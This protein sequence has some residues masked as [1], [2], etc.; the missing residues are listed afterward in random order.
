MTAYKY[1]NS[2]FTK[3]GLAKT[4]HNYIEESTSVGL[5][6]VGREAFRKN[7]KEHIEIINRKS[8]NYRNA[9]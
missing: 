2:E 1:F 3:N 4:Y 5:D 9:Y 6:K 8:I 7:Y